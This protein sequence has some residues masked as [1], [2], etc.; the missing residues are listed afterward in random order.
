MSIAKIDVDIQMSTELAHR[1]LK[2]RLAILE[3]LGYLVSQYHLLKTAKG[4][5]GWFHVYQALTDTEIAEL[6]FLLGDDQKRCRFNFLRDE[7]GAFKQFNA[8][9]NKKYKRQRDLI[10]EER[11]HKFVWERS[12]T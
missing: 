9:F 3:S 11:V 7:A 12:E 10:F 4:V 1:W 5:H 8:L 6:Q 2:T